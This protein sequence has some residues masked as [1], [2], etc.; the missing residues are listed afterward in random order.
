MGLTYEVFD[1]GLFSS[2]MF[3]IGMLIYDAADLYDIGVLSQDAPDYTKNTAWIYFWGATAFVLE[4]LSDIIWLLDW[5]WWYKMRRKKRT[6]NRSS[7]NDPLLSKES[8]RD[9]LQSAVTTT[10]RSAVTTMRSA[11]SL[12]A[13]TL[14]TSGSA[15]AIH[16][17]D[18]P[19]GRSVRTTF[20]KRRTCTMYT[21]RSKTMVKPT[22]WIYL[23][24]WNLW[25]AVF[26]FIPSLLYLAQS[27]IDPHTIYCPSFVKLLSEWRVSEVDY[28]KVTNAWAAWLFTL[29][30]L[31][32]VMAW[33]S[34]IRMEGEWTCEDWMLWADISFIVSA[35]F[36]VYS[37]YDIRT[38][39]GVISNAFWTINA[40]LYVI[41]S[42]LAL[43]E[44]RKLTKEN[45]S[46]AN[47][48]QPTKQYFATH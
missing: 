46:T 16:L 1:S 28:F 27:L 38:E 35:V 14:S 24:R 7:I 32:N 29:D 45:D 22:P 9:V 4:S 8:E 25:S 12:R 11:R 48:L 44:M 5:S 6:V 31:I 37:V 34:F 36:Q 17:D 19:V 30:S 40:I 26:F 2:T 18:G 20:G 33:W 41:G 42:S 13:D 23:I 15:G 3:L 21:K 39:I 10:M 43:Q 47:F